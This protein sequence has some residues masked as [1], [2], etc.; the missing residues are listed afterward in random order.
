[1][2]SLFR[3]LGANIAPAFRKL[4]SDVS[5]IGR[6]I[7][8]T[9]SVV[10]KGLAQAE[11]VTSQI[12]KYAP[13]PLTKTV[14]GAITGARDITGGV[15]VAG[16]ALRKASAG[17]VSGAQNLALSALAQGT[18]GVAELGSIGLGAFTPSATVASSMTA[19]SSPPMNVQLVG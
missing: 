17:D 8:N 11:K 6:K 9:A 12:D 18:R 1:M 14:K 10:D 3:K 2:A 5:T 7:T 15:G 13:N 16:Q 19:K 4:P